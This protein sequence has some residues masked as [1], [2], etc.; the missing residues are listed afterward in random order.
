MHGYLMYVTVTV[1]DA[2]LGAQP[3][4]NSKPILDQNRRTRIHIFSTYNEAALK[5]LSS[6]LCDVWRVPVIVGR[7]G[8]HS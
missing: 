5:L 1:A 8:T 2:R 3:S 7:R 6:Q 4:K